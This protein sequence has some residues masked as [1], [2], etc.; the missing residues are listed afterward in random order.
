MQRLEVRVPALQGHGSEWFVILSYPSQ[1]CVCD[2][3]PVENFIALGTRRFGHHDFLPTIVFQCRNFRSPAFIESSMSLQ[4]KR[5]GELTQT[6]LT[7][8]TKTFSASWAQSISL[9]SQHKNAKHGTMDSR[10]S[11]RSCG[12]AI[13]PW[14]ERP[15]RAGLQSFDENS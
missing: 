2:L 15:L 3:A 5:P 14:T 11:S 1:S 8:Q 6:L 13:T 12:T 4:P 9:Y 7:L 10:E